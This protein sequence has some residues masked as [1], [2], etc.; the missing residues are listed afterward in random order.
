MCFVL[1]SQ[2]LVVAGIVALS[3]LLAFAHWGIDVEPELHM[4]HVQTGAVPP[5]RN[6]AGDVVAQQTRSPLTR[7]LSMALLGEARE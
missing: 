7:P 6:V 2:L 1:R 4:V 5:V 3:A